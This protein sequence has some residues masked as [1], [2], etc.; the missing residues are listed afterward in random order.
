V[1]PPAV[2]VD[3]LV[4][5]VEPMSGSAPEVKPV[6]VK[7]G[8]FWMWKNAEGAAWKIEALKLASEVSGNNLD[9]VRLITAENGNMGHTDQS[10]VVKNGVREP[11]FGYCQIHRYYHPQTVNDER[12]FTDKRW[13]M[14]QC[15]QKWSTGTT[16][17]APPRPASEFYLTS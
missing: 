16:F 17:Y 3:E 14:E 13:Q 10:K 15:F 2:V 11:S 9:F 7:D 12:F 8:Q 4:L 6:E 1:Q 5:D